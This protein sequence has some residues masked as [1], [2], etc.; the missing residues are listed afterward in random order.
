MYIDDCINGTQKIFD[1]QIND[2]LNLG[3]EEQVSINQLVNMV[4]SIS[5]Y[6]VR[7]KYL[8]DKPKGV[9]GRSSDNSKL[10]KNIN[11]SPNI[12]LFNG[13]E[14]T[15]KWIF[16]QIKSGENTKKFIKS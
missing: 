10:K 3:S 16:N 7:K 8:L 6:S 14:M 15:Y 1:S 13:L 2:V 4:E 5:G 12:K 11:W 9:R